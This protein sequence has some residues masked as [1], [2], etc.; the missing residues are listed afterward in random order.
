VDI[1]IGGISELLEHQALLDLGVGSISTIPVFKRPLASASS[2]IALA[3]RSFT[4]ERGLKYSSLRRR[5]A[6][7]IPAGLINLR[8]RGRSV[9]PTSSVRLST[10]L[11]VIY[12]LSM[13]N[14]I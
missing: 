6:P 4:L 5:S 7:S 13:F 9:S 14:N 10:T 8:G 3:M 2:I 1:R 12:L 11:F